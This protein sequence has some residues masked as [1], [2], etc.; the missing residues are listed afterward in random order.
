MTN[1]DI[2][3][4]HYNTKSWKARIY[5][6]LRLLIF[7]VD[8]LVS[9]MPKKGTVLCLGCGYGTLEILVALKN[10]RLNIVASDISKQRIKIARKSVVD[11][12]NI[13]FSVLDVTSYQSKSKFDYIAFFD[14]LHHLAEG[15]QIRFLE[16]VWSSL[17]SGGTLIMK[18]VDTRPKWKYVWNLVH[19]RLMA[20]L[21]LTYYSS[22]F[23]ISY[24]KSKGAKV[25]LKIPNGFR[26][27]YN[28][29][30]LIVTKPSQT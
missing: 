15:E 23:Y 20:G 30:A 18:D 17:A 29:Y 9:L 13:T 5:H 3:L 26:S 25:D 10:S 22:K 2:L 21:P 6:R 14:L 24:F 4:V 16:H 11:V 1:L 19:D 7:P 28:H 12:P 27:P 8:W